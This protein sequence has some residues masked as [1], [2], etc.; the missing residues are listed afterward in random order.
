MICSGIICVV[1]VSVEI[2]CLKV[3][4]V[5]LWLI[6]KVN[7]KVKNRIIVMSVI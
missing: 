4:M 2:F 5:F 1:S 7:E 6:E 3:E